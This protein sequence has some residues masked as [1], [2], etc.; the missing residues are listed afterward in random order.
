MKMKN[1]N[2][3]KSKLNNEEK[4]LLKNLDNLEESELIRLA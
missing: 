4:S 2:N 3:K 1:L